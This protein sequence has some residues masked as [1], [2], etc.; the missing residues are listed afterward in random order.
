MWKRKIFVG[1]F[2]WK[3][4]K[5]LFFFVVFMAWKMNDSSSGLNAFFADFQTKQ[6]K[7][8][9]HSNECN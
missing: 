5:M 1:V 7:Y 3:N 2:L 4:A 6:I 8:V 9:K